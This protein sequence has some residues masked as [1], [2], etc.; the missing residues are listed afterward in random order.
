MKKTL[1]FA[2]VTILTLF[3]VSAESIRGNTVKLLDLSNESDLSTEYALGIEQFL[4]L[5][6]GEKAD[7]L[8]GFEISVKIP[9][10]LQ[11]Y[12]D[13]FI[14][15]LYGNV[16]PEPVEGIVKNYQG[17]ELAHKILSSRARQ[18]LDFGMVGVSGGSSELPKLS[19]Y[20]FPMTLMLLPMS[21]GVPSALDANP[22]ELK[23]TPR[24][25]N[26]G[27][28][29]LDSPLETLEGI[30]LW[31]D[32]E[33]VN[34]TGQ[35]LIL[36]SGIHKLS[37]RLDGFIDLNLNFAIKAGGFTNLQLP[38]QPKTSSVSFSAPE[39][40]IIYFDGNRLDFPL[41]SEVNTD[42]G[43]HSVLFKLGDYQISKQFTVI[44]GKDYEISLFLDILVQEN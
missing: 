29:I 6:V 18:Y 25:K 15:M 4:G 13:S 10:P 43:E 16:S 30:S 12:G 34:Y 42:E 22:F 40:C 38:F 35:K 20:D 32:D 41:E 1:L 24:W 7:F 21:K 17:V 2:L 26:L 8:E 27:G 33:M 39:R 36:S 19:P 14:L 31:I 9:G 23:V 11:Q 44:G 28:L 5:E 3:S 37:A